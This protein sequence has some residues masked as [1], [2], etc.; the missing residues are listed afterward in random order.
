MS[1][2]IVL[3]TSNAAK[4]AQLRWLLEGLP[5][6]PV[7]AAVAL[8]VPETAADLS[9][10]AA[11][12]ALAYSSEGLAIA[13]DGGLE[14]PALA[15]RWDPL[16]TQRQGRTRLRQL[17]AGL[18]DRRVLWSEAVAIA[19]GGQLLATWT[20][21]GTEGVLASEPWPAA[22]E[23]WAWDIFAFPE[24]GKVWAALSPAERELVDL[25]WGRLKANVQEFLR[26]N[27][28]FVVQ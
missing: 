2:P 24:V 12:K 10:N 20:E 11:A 15:G 27:C 3:A 28:T 7:E 26:A 25:T 21:S 19:E 14:V 22:S 8:D 1:Q 17:A 9:G 5:L 16:L 18:S 13:S 4:R 23:F 6:Q